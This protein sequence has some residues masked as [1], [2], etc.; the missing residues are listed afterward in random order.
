[1]SKPSGSDLLRK[2]IKLEESSNINNPLPPF[3][4][5]NIPNNNLLPN[6]INTNIMKLSS[7]L[8]QKKKF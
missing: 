8:I 7:R 3:T 4:N 2:F 5:M 6:N 1:M